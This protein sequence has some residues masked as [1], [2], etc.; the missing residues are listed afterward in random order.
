MRNIR[1]YKKFFNSKKIV[2]NFPKR[3]KFFK[4][5]KWKKFRL[6]NKKKI[7]R[8]YFKVNLKLN[9]KSIRQLNFKS[10][11]LKR[12]KFKN[13]FIPSLGKGKKKIVRIN[14]Y[15][16]ESLL[17]KNKILQNFDNYFNIIILKKDLLKY[18]S[19]SYANL[20][21]LL[22]I[23]NVYN[24]KI[25]LWKLHFS[26]TTSECAQYIN[27][28]YILV[29]NK[30]IFCDYF[31]KKGD[32]ITIERN[33]FFLNFKKNLLGYNLY[34][35]IYSFIEIDYYTCTLVVIKDFNELNLQDFSILLPNKFDTNK[36]LNYIR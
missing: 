31:L 3:L 27:S 35:K 15:Y 10:K 25:L 18:K 22:L 21:R 23:K 4:R 28:K 33:I 14:K 24:L 34:P 36:L 29:N 20:I 7:I 13:F 16:K 5:T 26:S 17:S 30:S 11:L 2:D 8:N 6:F 19:L 9:Y 1:I 32:V 12:F